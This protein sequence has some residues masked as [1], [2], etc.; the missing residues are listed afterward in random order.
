MKKLIDYLKVIFAYL[1]VCTTIIL[2]MSL[3]YM[4]FYEEPKQEMI[5]DKIEIIDE[6][7]LSFKEELYDY[8]KQI[9]VQHPD[10]VM[11]QAILESGYFTSPLFIEHNNFC[12]MTV[13][14]QRPTT[15]I[16][17]ENSIYAGYKNWQMCVIDYT[18]WQ[19]RYGLN[20]TREEYFELLKVY[21][22]DPNYI[23]KLKSLLNE[24][25]NNN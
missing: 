2:L 12:G 22:Q 7:I 14:R 4:K 6:S 1:V 5:E 19:I 17:I 16:P 24:Q 20:K 25:K 15:A 18:F 10:I 11:A 13:A 21:A 3:L 8:L 23:V 9:N